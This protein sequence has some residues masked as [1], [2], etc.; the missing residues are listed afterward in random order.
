M[1]GVSEA[2]RKVDRGP[3]E[4]GCPVRQEAD[5]VWKVR[6]YQA[7]RSVLRS[8]DTVQA[9]L[10]IETLPKMPSSMRLPVLYRDGAEHLEHR[11]QTAKYFTARYVRE[12]Y[13]ELMERVTDRLLQQFAVDGSADL[14]ELSFTLAVEVSATV[15]G[16]TEDMP[17]LSV[18]LNR[19]FPAEFGTPGFTSFSGLYWFGR[20]LGPIIGI[21]RKDVRPA[22]RAHRAEPREDLISHLLAE[23]CTTADI[24][25]EC[26]TYAA[27]GM[28][29]TREFICVAAW[30]LFSDHDLRE[31][32]LTGDESDR[33][34]LLE[35]ILRLEP[36]AGNLKRRTLTE[37]T[38]PGAEGDVVI[39]ADALV[40][41]ELGATNLDPEAFGAEAQRLCPD[42]ESSS[43]ILAPGLT[44]GDGAHKC[45]GAS[46]AVLE[47]EIFLTRLFA[48]PGLEM[49]GPPEVTVKHD[50][51]FAVRGL[52]I[53][54]A[55]GARS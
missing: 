2:V 10:G 39:P 31:R 28:V 45:P 47:A 6:G 34:R 12:N 26:I 32:Y 5:G 20:R 23:G 37:I 16:L 55:S 50:S 35:E 11:R 21:Y 1:D 48:L 18:R 4:V 9:G 46:L 53:T 41:I 54:T 40:D 3:S 36:V 7:G 15:I 17:G 38:V 51:I 44:F 43:G 27:A 30:H 52:R 13:R 19:F 42:R 14:G 25:G 22:V 24:L 49:A 29:T 33:H 8:K